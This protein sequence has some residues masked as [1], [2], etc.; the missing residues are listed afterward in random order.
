MASSFPI[1]SKVILQ[2]LVKGVQY[3]GQKGTVKSLPDKITLRQNV[4]LHDTN[5]SMAV[6]PI[7]LMYEPRELTTLSIDEMS[8]LLIHT[9]K[10]TSQEMTDIFHLQ[11]GGKVETATGVCRRWCGKDSV[12]V[13]WRNYLRRL[14]QQKMSFMRS[15]MRHTRKVPQTKRRNCLPLII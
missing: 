8:S 11:V 3:N 12:I 5:K 2:N 7:N 10:A 14:K 1:G 15:K 4:V 6:K 13:A 9:K